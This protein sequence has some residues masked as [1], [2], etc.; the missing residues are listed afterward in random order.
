MIKH[1]SD[2]NN[3]SYKITFTGIKKKKEVKAAK[4]V[5]IK[6]MVVLSA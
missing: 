1:L 6:V 5:D 3:C 2:V 4:A